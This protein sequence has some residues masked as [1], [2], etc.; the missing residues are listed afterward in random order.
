MAMTNTQPK[1]KLR[2]K[3]GHYVKAALKYKPEYDRTG[4][5][6]VNHKN[7]HFG[8]NATISYALQCLFKLI[9]KRAAEGKIWRAQLYLHPG[10]VQLLDWKEGQPL[11]EPKY[12]AET[13]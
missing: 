11:I 13:A 6:F 4:G 3:A 2:G 12:N 9:Q 7:A 5:N 1:K 8:T 10:N